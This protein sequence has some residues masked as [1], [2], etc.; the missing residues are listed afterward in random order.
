MKALAGH[1]EGIGAGEPKRAAAVRIVGKAVGAALHQREVVLMAGQRG[2]PLRKRIARADVVELRE[3]CFLGHTE[4]DAE[5]YHP[6]RRRWWVGRADTATE[7]ERLER[8]QSH[9]RRS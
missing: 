2:E 5:E 3:P 6:L 7:S 1:T 8:R 4:A 9:E